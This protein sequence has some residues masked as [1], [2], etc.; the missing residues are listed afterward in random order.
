MMKR[1]A[2]EV[3]SLKKQI[4]QKHLAARQT[5]G[6]SSMS[7]S[8]AEM[9]KRRKNHKINSQGTNSQRKNFGHGV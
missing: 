9:N 5:N 4:L 6:S 2:E 3:E 1:L 7:S 8:E